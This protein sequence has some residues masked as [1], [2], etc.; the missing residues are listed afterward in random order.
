MAPPKL[1][2]DAPVPDVLQPVEV[3]LGPAFGE[4]ADE[5]FGDGSL[6]FLYAGIAEEPLLGEAWL[7][8]DVGPFGEADVIGVGFFIHEIALFGQLLD[9]R[10]AGLET[11]HAREGFAGQLVQGAV[12][13]QDVDE[14]QVVALA[15][16]KVEGV[17]SRSDLE[18]A[19]PEIFFNGF[20]RD[21]RNLAW[22]ERSADMLAL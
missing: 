19:G 5:T 21:E 12:G 1:A 4:V 10:L 20:V 22:I 18:H 7:D 9:A 13:I 3:G 14:R 16:L 6:G 15:D 2:A 8:G 11:I 17:V